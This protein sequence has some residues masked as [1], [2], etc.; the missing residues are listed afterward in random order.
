M[1]LGSDAALAK[2][3]LRR[4]AEVGLDELARALE[5]RHAVLDEQVRRPGS[6]EMPGHTRA[7]GS[8]YRQQVVNSF[9][10]TFSA[11]KSVSIVW[12][13]AD[14]ELRADIEQAM[15]DAT[16]AALEHVT[17][18]RPVISG[19]EPAEGFAAALAIHVTARTAEGD[20]V[21]MP[22][23]HVHADLVGVL[24]RAGGLKTPNS[25]ALFKDAAMREAGAVGRAALARR[26]EELGFQIEARTGKDG[27]YF[28]IVGVPPGLIE[29]MS[30][31]SRDV[32]AWVRAA[33]E[34]NGG[35]L[36]TREAA[37]GALAT[38]SPKTTL[39]GELVQ[40]TWEQHRREFGF[41]RVTLA[42]LRAAQAPQRDAAALREAARSEILQ[43]VFAQGPTVSLGT[44]RAIAYELAPMG[45]ALD[46]VTGLL[47]DMQA[48]GELVVLDKWQVTTREIRARE[49]YVQRVAI[50][51]GRERVGAPGEEAIQQGMAVANRGLGEHSLDAEQEAAVRTLTRGA[52][53]NALG[54][55]AG[56]G[57]GPVLQ[58]VA[59]AHR[60]EGWTVV[61]AAVDGATTQRLGKQ[62]GASALTVQ[63]LLYRLRHERL[64][65]G[66]RTLIVID[67]AGKVG[68]RDWAA[69]AQVAETTRAR[70]LVV[71]DVEQIGAIEAPGML[72]VML[73]ADPDIP[74]AHLTEVR[75]HRD[76]GD[77]S[78][79]H[80]WLAEYQKELYVG[81]ADT[82][83]GLLRSHGAITMHA[84]RTAAM[85]GLVDRWEQR[86]EEHGIEA[87]D[88]ILIVHG[89]N[90]D[91]D[92]VN[93]LAQS[94]R[95]AAGEVRGEGVD[96]LSGAYKLYEQDVVMLRDGAYEPEIGSEAGSSARR[97]ENGTLGVV[98]R[99]DAAR[100]RLWVAFDDPAGGSRT[101]MIDQRALREQRA[102]RPP[103]GPPVADLRLA[104]A[105]HPFPMQGATFDYVGS[106][107][108]HWSQ[109]KEETYSGDTRARCWLD[110]HTDRESAG[111]DGGD[112]DRYA[113]LAKRL[114]Q[115]SHKQA[116]ITFAT[117]PGTP[118]V[119]RA[120]L[121]VDV[122]PTLAERAG[123][124]AVS[125]EAASRADALDAYLGMLGA[126][127]V[128]R[129]DARAEHH[130]DSVAGLDVDALVAVRD[131]GRA[132]GGLLDGRAAYEVR[133]IEEAR[134]EVVARLELARAAERA[135]REK[136]EG[137]SGFRARRERAGAL[138][139]A[140][141]QR[142]AAGQ[143]AAVLRELAR[144]ELELQRDGVHPDVWMRE[145]GDALARGIAAQRRLDAELGV[146][147]PR[148]SAEL[149]AERAPLEYN[150]ELDDHY[151]YDAGI[152][153]E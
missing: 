28:E 112:D 25:M 86:R 137:L 122:V 56:T 114:S 125:A 55:L 91:V 29:R 89:T 52:G 78:R 117:A 54:G 31:R 46:D 141:T 6:A 104:Y 139:A 74:V 32:A 80:P 126:E 24:D 1:W 131:A 143:D 96:A 37:R 23:L 43:R 115:A 58:A 60:A 106:L 67:E 51:R 79:I 135:L 8:P 61:A 107:W 90:E 65:V 53:W 72:D 85:V 105:G 133:R 128:E 17:R 103:E 59:E 45:L 149:L 20:P 98:T 75:R 66:D 19:R 62:I 39:A 47:R 7:D 119:G 26:L 15:L 101:V 153:L 140:G 130:A 95:L 27:R 71:G 73:A 120:P 92:R 13:A 63:Q 144:R 70:F 68:L 146:E 16:N 118:L 82:A 132:A 148:R 110:V 81:H 4:G 30:G 116:S 87:R 152:D 49:Q 121:G 3:G 14:R 134:P 124:E 9:D 48:K 129:L 111:R 150:I 136:A 84:D 33:E 10:L 123:G 21:P 50:E 11:P 151:D 145:H 2:L 69:L 83:I 44:L 77:R 100:E 147:D 94:R 113:R 40:E 99:A 22:Q 64:V 97:V 108:G 109:R 142:I 34:A 127:R 93:A 35:R 36:S 88:A 102:T 138:A 18:T 12:S 76:P 42:E 5:G 57:K 41:G 38:R